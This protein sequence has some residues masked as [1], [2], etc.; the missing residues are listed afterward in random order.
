MVQFE[1]LPPGSLSQSL[2]V[3]WRHLK[4][5]ILATKGIGEGRRD[6]EIWPKSIE[7]FL[8]GMEDERF[9]RMRGENEMN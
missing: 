2:P 6:G 3:D 4:M 1:R 9:F 7:P 8:E 5:P